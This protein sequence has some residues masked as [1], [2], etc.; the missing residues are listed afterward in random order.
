MQA[1]DMVSSADRYIYKTPADWL[2]MHNLR[3]RM[4]EYTH[5]YQSGAHQHCAGIYTVP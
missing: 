5:Q 1:S 3:G 2:N 4:A